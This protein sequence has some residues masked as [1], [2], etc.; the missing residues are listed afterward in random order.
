M[1]TTKKA[2]GKLSWLGQRKLSMHQGMCLA[3]KRFEEQSERISLESRE[4]SGDDPLSSA[5]RERIARAMDD[6]QG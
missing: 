3:C 4:L 1:L 2:E 6:F 5:A